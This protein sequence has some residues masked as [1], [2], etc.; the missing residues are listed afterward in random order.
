MELFVENL[1]EKEIIENFNLLVE[2][3]TKLDLHRRT[4]I[5]SLKDKIKIENIEIY[6]KPRYAYIETLLLLIIEGKIEVFFSMEKEIK[7][8]IEKY[9]YG[10]EKF[11][12]FKYNIIKKKLDNYPES[13]NG[14]Y[15][16]EKLI[17]FLEE[18]N[19]N[20]EKLYKLKK[21]KEDF[22]S[23]SESTKSNILNEINLKEL[24]KNF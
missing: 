22:D 20:S 11:Y 17:K 1:S 2:N 15:H 14:Y 6:N 18:T 13:K 21:V 3:F 9:D 24:V 23:K 7:E 8:L 16:I 4:I 12:E 10:K 5:K 19:L